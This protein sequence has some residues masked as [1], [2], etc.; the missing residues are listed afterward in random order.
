MKAS[1]CPKVSILNNNIMNNVIPVTSRRIHA[2]LFLLAISLGDDLSAKPVPDN[3][4]NG[5]NKLVESNLILKGQIPA[6]PADASAKPDGTTL[7]AGKS[8]TTYNGYATRQ[9]ANYAAHAITDRASKHFMVDIH[10]SGTV[11]F[12]NVQTALTTKFGS[13]QITA[14]DPKY[15][16]VGVI[17]GYISTDDVV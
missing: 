1:V 10:L 9:A 16:G 4:G 5:L 7:V 11:P 3:L 13:L 2:L 15:R 12:A 6:P 8:V 14:V 17:E